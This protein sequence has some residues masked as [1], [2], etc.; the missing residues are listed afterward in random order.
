M[1][2]LHLTFFP[3]LFWLVVGHVIADYPWQGDFL[4]TA[5]DRNTPIGKLFWPHALGA[6]AMIHAGF[7]AL[8]TGSVALGL[9]EAVIHALTDFLKCEK[10]ISLNTDQAIHFACKVLWAAIAAG[11]FA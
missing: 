7:V 11:A 1:I 2:Q 3:L 9:A 10:R 5:K 8:F 6:H 4:A